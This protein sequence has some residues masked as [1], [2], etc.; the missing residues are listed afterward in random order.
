MATF[1]ADYAVNITPK[2]TT[3]LSDGVDTVITVN[4]NIDKVLG[5]A[6][7]GKSWGT[8]AAK[9]KYDATYTTTTT[10]TTGWNSIIGS[11][12]TAIVTFLFMRIISAASSGTPNVTVNY[13]DGVTDAF[14]I[15]YLSGVGDCFLLPLNSNE[16]RAYATANFKVYSTGATSIANVETLLIL[17]GEPN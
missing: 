6:I 2:E 12:P 7:S 3:L 10:T 14:Q 5:S 1:T 4:S 11:S 13:D 8:D 17:G 9:I 16:A 15:A